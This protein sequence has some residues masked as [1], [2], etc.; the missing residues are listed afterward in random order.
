MAVFTDFAK[1]NHLLELLELE[2]ELFSFTVWS[3]NGSACLI[4]NF[5][6]NYDT[7]DDPYYDDDLQGNPLLRRPDDRLKSTDFAVVGG[8]CVMCHKI[9]FIEK[10]S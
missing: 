9:Q 4:S 5:R 3:M 7:D 6:E 2:L 10:F 1:S 8:L